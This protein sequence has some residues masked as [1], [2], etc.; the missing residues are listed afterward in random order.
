MMAKK[1]IRKHTVSATTMQQLFAATATTWR[2]FGSEDLVAKVVAYKFYWHHLPLKA[3]IAE[4]R[5]R[6]GWEERRRQRGKKGPSQGVRRDP[7]NLETHCHY[8]Q[9]CDLL[10]MESEKTLQAA[11]VIVS[12]AWERKWTPKGESGRWGEEAG[13]KWDH[14][15]GKSERTEE[16]VVAASGAASTNETDTHAHFLSF[17][18]VIKCS[19]VLPSLFFH[20]LR[21]KIDASPWYNVRNIIRISLRMH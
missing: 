8:L 21:G 10:K 16:C 18:L 9:T 4:K 7:R 14:F 20:M 12:L 13:K 6:E 19:E 15:L 2:V 5:V 3:C 1:E 17:V 11:K